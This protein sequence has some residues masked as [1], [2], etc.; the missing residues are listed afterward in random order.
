MVGVVAADREVVRLDRARDL[1]PDAYDR[2][3]DAASQHE[4]HGS[5]PG[6]RPA[7][8]R[9]VQHEQQHGRQRDEREAGEHAAGDQREGMVAD[10]FHLLRA[11]ADGW[12]DFPLQRRGEP[13]YQADRR[14]PFERPGDG[15]RAQQIQHPTRG[16]GHAE[17]AA[18]PQLPGNLIADLACGGHERGSL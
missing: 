4:R 13:L 14:G 3:G 11:R 18:A 8:A 12:V 15:D 7:K 16:D 6:L 5:R 9:G 17:T 10:E 2:Q 1:V